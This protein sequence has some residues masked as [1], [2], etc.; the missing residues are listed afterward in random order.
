[1][2]SSYEYDSDGRKIVGA[3][4]RRSDKKQDAPKYKT[5]SIGVAKRVWE[6]IDYAW[7]ERYAIVSAQGGT[8][9]GKTYNIMIW[10][11]NL[12][13]THDNYL[14][15]ITRKTAPTIYGTIFQD[16]RSVMMQMGQWD[17]DCWREKKQEYVIPSTGSIFRFF[18]SDEAAKQKGRKNTIVWMNEC[19]EFKYM[20]MVQLNVRCEKMLVLDYNPDY[21]EEF[22][23]NKI[24]TRKD[25]HF[26]ISTYTDNPFLDDRIIQQIEEL[27]ESNPTLWKM[28][29]EGKRCRIAGLIIPQFEIIDEFPTDVKMKVG[30]AMDFGFS[31]DPTAIVRVGLTDKAIYVDE[32]CYRK[33]L[34]NDQIAEVLNG[35]ELAGLPKVSENADPKTVAELVEK[36]HVRNLRKVTKG[37]Q[38]GKDVRLGWIRAMQAKRWYVTR[39]SYNIIKE[40]HNWCWKLDANG[41]PLNEP[42]AM[43]DHAMDAIRY[44]LMTYD[45]RRFGRYRGGRPSSGR[46]GL[47]RVK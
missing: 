29:G 27:K 45:T 35:R 4:G 38:H 28:Y 12:A 21:S 9:S 19:T 22:W 11:V 2:G 15:G 10:L 31:N 24:N 8:R 34:F 26:F 1:M 25:C 17:Q 18:P 30:V 14:I 7:R 16:F 13:L 40:L 42:V 32:R 20:D 47:I 33:G 39:D 37:G 43:F 23:L 36:Y 6:N 3:G 5:G 44:Y 41:E 46:T